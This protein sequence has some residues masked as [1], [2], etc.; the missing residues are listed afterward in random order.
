MT[1]GQGFTPWSP[2]HFYT[3][4]VI[5]TIGFISLFPLPTWATVFSWALIGLGLWIALDDVWQHYR[6]KSDPEYHSLWHNWYWSSLLWLI[7]R[8]P[9][10]PIRRILEWLR[11]V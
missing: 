9:E 3:G 7:A 8:T 2:H 11:T 6:Q 5:A 4:L 10:G 1:K